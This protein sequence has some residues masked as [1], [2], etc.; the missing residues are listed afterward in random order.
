MTACHVNTKTQAQTQYFLRNFFPLTGIKRQEKKWKNNTSVAVAV[1][2]KLIG[3][4]LSVDTTH[5]S[6]TTE[7]KCIN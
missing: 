5:K 7:I 6:A 2:K 3:F 4:S 1:A